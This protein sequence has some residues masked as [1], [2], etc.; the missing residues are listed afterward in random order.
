MIEIKKGGKIYSKELWKYI[1][2]TDG[3]FVDE[4]RY[5]K[6]DTKFD[7]MSEVELVEYGYKLSK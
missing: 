2:T 5:L 4:D 1:E 6:G 3:E 7:L